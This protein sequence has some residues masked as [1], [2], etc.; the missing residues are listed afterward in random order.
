[1]LYIFLITFITIPK[2]NIRFA[3]TALGF[4]LGNMLSMIVN[5]AFR[6]SKSASDEKK[7]KLENE[8]DKKGE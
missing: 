4:L 2:E 6:T 8:Q 7:A 1:M 5:W 3:D